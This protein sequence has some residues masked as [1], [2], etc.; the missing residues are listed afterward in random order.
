[1]DDVSRETDTRAGKVYREASDIRLL[2]AYQLT[3]RPGSGM[4]LGVGVWEH[5]SIPAVAY[6]QILQPGLEVVLPEKFS[7][8]RL[9][10]NK[11]QPVDPANLSKRQKGLITD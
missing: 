5:L 6:H 2:D 11:F 8:L 4:S 3:I 1:I 10:W 9:R 7:G